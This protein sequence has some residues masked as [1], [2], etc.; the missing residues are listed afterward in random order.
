MVKLSPMLDLRMTAPLLSP[1]KGK[2]ITPSM[3]SE[4]HIVSVGNECKELLVVMKREQEDEGTKER[5]F[6]TK[7]VC[8]NIL[9]HGVTERFEFDYPSSET[10]H[11]SPI[12]EIRKGLF[13]YEPNASIMKAGCFAEVAAHFNVSPIGP[14]SHLFVSEELVANFPGRRFLISAVSS[15]NKKELKD[16]LKG[17]SKANLTVRNFPLSVAEL[18]KRLKLADGGDLYLFATTQG[19][20][21]HILLFT[22]KI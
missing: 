6:H 10:Y 2:T 1:Y 4:I 7:V 12:G 18:R 21:E 11:S 5:D 8:V 13:L 16:H 19:E 20:K 15:M 22:K 3:K 17:I 14:N 9:G